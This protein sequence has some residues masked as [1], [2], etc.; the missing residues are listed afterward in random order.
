MAF[1]LSPRL[2]PYKGD[3]RQDRSAKAPQAIAAATAFDVLQ[4]IPENGDVVI[5]EVKRNRRERSV[6]MAKP[7]KPA[8]AKPDAPKA[9]KQQ[10]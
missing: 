6:Q 10:G 3:P 1:P 7:T 4:Y 9:H 8:E 5:V 2:R